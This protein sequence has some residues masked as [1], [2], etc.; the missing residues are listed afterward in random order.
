MNVL[1]YKKS[2]QDLFDEWQLNTGMF[3]KN[4]KFSPDGIVNPDIW[5]G[6]VSNTRIL[7]VLKETNN[8]CNLCDYVCCKKKDGHNIKWQTWYNLTRWTYLLRH[9]HDQSFDEMWKRVK[10]VDEGKRIYNMER[11]ALVNVKKEPGGKITDTDELKN[12]FEKYNKAYLPREIA[13]FGHI[14]YIV[15][16]GKGVSHCL[17]QCYGGLDWKNKHTIARIADGTLVIDFVHPQSREKKN[18]LFKRL[19]DIVNPIINQNKR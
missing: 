17:S 5:F 8:W 13:L 15:C 4:Q 10:Y 6:E 14:D 9:I 12:A 3:I 18:D 1:D 7:F 19:Y 16:C 11:V 2:L